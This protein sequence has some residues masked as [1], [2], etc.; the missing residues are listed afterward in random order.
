MLVDLSRVVPASASIEGAVRL[1]SIDT[2]APVG[3]AGVISGAA[4]L[5][6]DGV[7]RIPAKALDLVGELVGAVAEQRSTAADR[8]GRVPSSENPFVASG[9]ERAPVMSQAAVG[10]RRAVIA[11]AGRRQVVMA[12]PW[13]GGHRWAV[14]FTHDVDV[15]AWWPAFSA[16]RVAELLRGGHV[17]LAGRVIGAFL[18]TLGRDPVLA[19]IRRVLDV[20][21]RATLPATWFFLSGTPSLRSMAAGDVTYGVESRR[22]R[23]VVEAVRTAGHEIGLHGSFATCYSRLALEEER[24]RLRRVSGSPVAGVRQHFLRMR[25][26]RTQRAMS[27]AG[28][29]YDATYGFPDRSGFRLGVADIVP[30]WDADAGRRSGVEEVPLVWMDRALSKYSG[31]E[32]PAAWV[33]DA[34][35]LLARCASVEGLWTGLWHPNLTG[36]LGF[37]GAE[38]ALEGIVT[39]A[40]S[41]APYTATIQQLVNWRRARRALIIEEVAPDGRLRASTTAST[42]DPART[43]APRIEDPEMRAIPLRALDV[44]RRERA[45]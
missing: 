8:H 32:D 25:P 22:V 24:E 13:P 37:I 14:A 42:D 20:E 31:V 7:V 17:A 41:K 30:G 34:A 43:P 19:G 5:V 28:F 38:Q 11:A 45:S 10:L 2:D 1:E 4:W 33:A 15:V 18:R 36:P 16:L 35:Q 26:G 6:G 9:L 12:A 23:R 44:V 27:E 3:V 39:S 21:R 29:V 40:V